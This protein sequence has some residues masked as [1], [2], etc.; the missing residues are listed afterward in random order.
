MAQQ[1]KQP[2]FIIMYT[3]TRWAAEV[4]GLSMQRFLE[5]YKPDIETNCFGV[6][7]LQVDTR[8]EHRLREFFDHEDLPHRRFQW[9]ADVPL[10]TFAYF[11]PSIKFSLIGWYRFR[12][13]D[14]NCPLLRPAK[15]PRIDWQDEW[16]L[17]KMNARQVIQSELVRVFGAEAG[18]AVPTFEILEH[19]VQYY[20][21]GL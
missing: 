21:T 17:R 15:K 10:P 1:C 8:L 19:L 2:A 9:R 13:G 14:P 6:R 20:N 4:A 5:A 3:A 18:G 16:W 12:H 7:E 11:W